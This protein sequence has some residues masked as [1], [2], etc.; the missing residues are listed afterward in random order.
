MA[1]ALKLSKPWFVDKQ[2]THIHTYSTY[3]PPC[4]PAS[5]WQLTRLMRQIEAPGCLTP[6]FKCSQQVFWLA[7]SSLIPPPEKGNESAVR[8]SC[9]GLKPGSMIDVVLWQSK[10]VS[11]FWL[12]CGI[13]F[14]LPVV[15]VGQGSPP[16]LS[17]GCRTNPLS[18]F[19]L[20]SDRCTSNRRELL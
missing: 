14:F 2:K 18:K 15:A 4:N 5:Q 16:L 6:I 12:F 9:F 1:S 19:G 3:T 20:W 11:F 17:D 10:V 8:R 13:G 7:G